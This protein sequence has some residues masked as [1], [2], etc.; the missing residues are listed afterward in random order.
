M[1]EIMHV[2]DVQPLEGLRIRATFS[3][4]AIKEST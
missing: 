3:D 4:G 1:N 2:T